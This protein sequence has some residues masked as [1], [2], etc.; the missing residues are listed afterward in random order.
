[1]IKMT[2]TRILGVVMASALAGAA[3]GGAAVAG[4]PHMMNALNDLQAARSQL[5]AAED[6]KGGHRD[7]AIQLVDQAIGEVN[8]GIAY[9]Q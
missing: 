8:A 3:I 6:N 1:M 9:A 5:A 7:N 2:K 4:Q